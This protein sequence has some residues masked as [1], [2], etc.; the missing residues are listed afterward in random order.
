MVGATYQ[1]ATIETRCASLLLLPGFVADP[2]ADAVGVYLRAI[3]PIAGQLMMV[4]PLSMA[5]DMVERM[6]GDSFVELGRLEISALGEAG[7][8]MS[9]YFLREL[10]QNSQVSARPSPP[11]VSVDML[12]TIL[13]TVATSDPEIATPRILTHAAFQI[14]GAADRA[15]FWVVFDSATPCSK[16]GE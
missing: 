13:E 6:T 12:S 8:L 4:M 5:I 10:E 1:V 9:G 14:Q 15:D 11:M 7:N 3:G 16:E 2:E